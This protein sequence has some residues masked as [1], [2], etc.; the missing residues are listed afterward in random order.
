M[1]T[2]V[3]LLRQFVNVCKSNPAILY[4]P[5]FKFYRDYLESLGAKLP[6]PPKEPSETKSSK[7]ADNSEELPKNEENVEPEEE[8]ELDM[9]GVIK[10]E[11]D[12]PLPMGDNNKEITEEDMEKAT[13]QRM[14]AINAF[15]EGDFEKAVVHFSKAIELNPGLAVLHAKRANALLKLNK[16]NGAIRDCDKAISLNA[17]SAQSYKIRGRA[18]R[19]LGNFVEAHRDLAMAC[20]LDYDDEANVWLKEVEPN[21]VI[22]TRYAT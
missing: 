15:N 19:L 4:E 17:D 10:G 14:L 22:I 3:E 9:S 8:L 5:K 18:H 2:K 1:D 7:P 13:E 12:E 16:P 21:N 20:K 11:E 6:P